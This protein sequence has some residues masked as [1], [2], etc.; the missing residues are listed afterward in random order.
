MIKYGN[1]KSVIFDEMN[2]QLYQNHNNDNI[3]DVFEK[4]IK[5]SEAIDSFP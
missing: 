5:F 2:K 3:P 1:N 4:I